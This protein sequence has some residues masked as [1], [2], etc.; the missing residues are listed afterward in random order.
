M[1]RTANEDERGVDVA[2]I[3]ERLRMTPAER[4]DRLV[5]EVEIWTAIRDSVSPQRS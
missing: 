5:H 2:Q 1:S 4:V 3:R